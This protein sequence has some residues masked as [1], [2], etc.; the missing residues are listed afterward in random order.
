MEKNYD[1]YKF[2]SLQTIKH[3]ISS[4][5]IQKLILESSIEKLE[6]TE[7]NYKVKEAVIAYLRQN[8]DA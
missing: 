6:T 2:E 1:K 5:L 3:V 7:I 4:Y 8:D